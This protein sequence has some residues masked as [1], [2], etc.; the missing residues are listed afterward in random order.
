MNEA[1]DAPGGG[2]PGH[3]GAAVVIRAAV[4]GDAAALV[5]LRVVMFAA[6]GTDAAALADSRWRDAARDWF[7]DRVGT[8]GVHAIV[9]E[10]GGEVVSC[11]VG[12]VTAL[13]PG[14]SAPHGSVGL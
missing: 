6:M 1:D 2:G 5:A 12:E 4:A 11:A 9:A 8:A 14:P 3:A 10:V 7:A 13:I